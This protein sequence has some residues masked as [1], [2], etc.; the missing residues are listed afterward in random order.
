MKK[1]INLSNGI[2][3]FYAFLFLVLGIINICSNLILLL[4]GYPVFKVTLQMK[5]FTLI[6]YV[7]FFLLI[8]IGIAVYTRK[9]WAARISIFLPFLFVL[10]EYIAE[11]KM[12]MGSYVIWLFF[13]ISAAILFNK[14]IPRINQRG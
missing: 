12:T 3:N 2:L 5:I 7:Y 4:R 11:T 14:I 1:N 9:L 13:L 8:V 10:F 6:H